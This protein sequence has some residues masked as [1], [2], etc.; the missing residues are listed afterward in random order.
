MKNQVKHYPIVTAGCKAA[1]SLDFGLSWAVLSIK[2]TH[3]KGEVVSV[4]FKHNPGMCWIEEFP[5]YTAI[6]I[7]VWTKRYYSAKQAAVVEAANI[8]EVNKHINFNASEEF[9]TKELYN[10]LK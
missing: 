8:I 3:R 9:I 6:R 2:I 1:A 4:K 5:T 7:D 10:R